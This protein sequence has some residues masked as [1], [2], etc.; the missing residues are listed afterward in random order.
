LGGACN[1]KDREGNRIKTLVGRHERN[2]LVDL[3]VDGTIVLR[4]IE[5]GGV[6][7]IHLALDRGL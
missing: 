7:L 4:E 2:L 1:T 6:E 5:W 3:G